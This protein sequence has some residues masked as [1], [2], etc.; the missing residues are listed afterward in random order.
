[1]STRQKVGLSMTADQ[2]KKLDEGGFQ[3]LGSVP[4]GIAWKRGSIVTV[5]FDLDA[6]RS[7]LHANREGAA[8]LSPGV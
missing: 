5:Q 8:P 1:M 3:P 7:L 4:G 2:V 6:V